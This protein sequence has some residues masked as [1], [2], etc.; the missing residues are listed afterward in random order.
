[1]FGENAKKHYIARMFKK[2]KGGKVEH[3]QGLDCNIPPVGWAYNYD[4][5]KLFKIGVFKNSENPIKQK[6]TRTLAPLEKKFVTER[7]RQE[8]DPGYFDDDLEIFRRKEWDRRL[9]GYWF[10]N[11]GKPTFITGLHYFYLNYWEIDIGYPNYRDVDRKW[12]YFVSYCDQDPNCG[13]ILDI[14]KRRGGKSY[15]GGCYLYEGVSRASK[16]L[17]AIQSKTREDAR[18]LFA[19]KI[20]EPFQSVPDFFVPEYDKA[21]GKRP[22]TELRFF[23]TN[24][25]GINEEGDKDDL[26]SLINFRDSSEKAYDGR[27]IHRGL[28]DEYGKVED[29][30]IEERHR[31]LK[32]CILQDGKI[33]GKLMYVTTV[34]DMGRGNAR[35]NVKKLWNESDVNK[36]NDNDRTTSLLYRYFIEAYESE[37]FDEYG[38]SL[39]D[40]AVTYF[41]NIFKDFEKKGDHRSL[42][43][44]KRKNPFTIEDV[45]RSDGDTCLFNAIEISNR[46][47][48]L[49]WKE[50]SILYDVGNFLWESGIG[51]KVVWNP[52][53]SGRFKVRYF[54]HNKEGGGDESNNVKSYGDLRIPKNTNSF[55]IGCDPYDHDF[56]TGTPSDAAF[57][58]MKKYDPSDPVFS[59]SLIVEYCARPTP[60]EFYE[61]VIKAGVYYGCMILFENQKYGL[62]H[63]MEDHGYGRF[64]MHFNNSLNPGIAASQ[65]SKQLG[66]ETAEIYF[67]ENMDKIF[68]PGL[69]EDALEFTITETTKYDRFMAFMWTLIASKY[70]LGKVNNNGVVIDIHSIYKQYRINA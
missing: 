38:M 46:L 34:E 41:N 63:Y 54:L 61:D 29:V 62:K 70:M 15:R 68:F 16:K 35:R 24:K 67:S 65:S 59:N 31:T 56:S 44:E 8:S 42:A 18:A 33:I 48:E 11:N 28:V 13:G 21:G 25:K 36:R 19:E 10:Y 58:V 53:P 1:M 9:Y 57:Y 64:L 12:F 2:I 30:N 47:S 39:K 69:L 66:A 50:E 60:K 17:G 27:K 26:A 23:A 22:K 14:E 40:K 45:F 6:F 49:A 43:S 52:N 37:F 32:Y 3:I 20:I 7:T 55:V 4:D 5:D 51:S